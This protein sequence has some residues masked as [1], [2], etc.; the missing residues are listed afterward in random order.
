[1][2]CTYKYN[3]DFIAQVYEESVKKYCS[4]PQRKEQPRVYNT[5]SSMLKETFFLGA[6][7]FGDNFIA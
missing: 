3:S 5:M 4:F 1:M 6:T 2:Q 7:R